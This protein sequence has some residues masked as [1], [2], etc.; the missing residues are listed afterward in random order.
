MDTFQAMVLDK[1]NGQTKLE[2]KHL[3]MDDLP[4]GEVTIRVAY[5][6]VNFKDG[7]V[8]IQ[9]Q[10]V[11][12]YP[13]VPGIDLAGTIINS[14]DDRFKTGDEVIVTSYKLGTGHFGGFSEI[15]RVPADWVVPL[16]NGL[17]L[18]EAMILGTAGFTAALSIQRLEEN[19][20]DP[21]QGPVLVAGATGGVGSIAV[22]ILAKRGYEVVA[23]T[24]KTNEEDYLR[25]LGA[26][27]I[28]NRNEIIDTEQIPMREEKWAGA[29]DPVGGKTLQYI[30]STLKYGG[31]VATCGLTGGIEVSTT[32]LPYIS[33]GVNW[34]G[35]D[36]VECPMQK[37]LKVWNR[38]GD[39]LK[40]TTF[41]EELVNEISLKELPGVLADILEGKVRGRTLVKL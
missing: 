35:I 16:P 33:R 18:K 15:A 3:S 2:I 38:L 31:S 8:S 40:P 9:N 27:Q 12:S 21:S 24:G 22:N 6:S 36:S 39:D 14:T 41:N 34:L 29:I 5:S 4:D 25:G 28:L 30:V 13:L 19:D 10:L 32:V 11:E 26:T 23:S 7:I 37:R 1:V 20:L 17:T